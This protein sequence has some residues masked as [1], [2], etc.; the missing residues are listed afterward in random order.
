MMLPQS[1]IVEEGSPISLQC[2]VDKLESE[3]HA[4]WSRVDTKGTMIALGAT[5]LGDYRHRANVTTSNT[6]SILTIDGAHAGDSGVYRC[7]LAVGPQGNRPGV[8][9]VVS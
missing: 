1:L 3:V 9:H 8:E 5:L 6:S 7:E 4:M 2:I